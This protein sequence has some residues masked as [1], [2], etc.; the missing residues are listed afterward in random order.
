MKLARV[1]A[2]VVCT[3]KHAFYRGQKTFMVKPL[4][5]DGTFE[6][7]TMVAV[8]RVQSGP[9]DTVLVMQEGSSARFMFGE[10]EAPV[11]SVIVGI[12]DSVDLEG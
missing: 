1:I 7:Q 4:R 6:G 2:Q 8:D 9:G 12:V 10:A 3:Q 5:L 11:R